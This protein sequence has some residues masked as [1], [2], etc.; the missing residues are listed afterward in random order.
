VTA[1][2]VLGLLAVV[3]L[4]WAG[5]LLRNHEVGSDAALRS[6]FA[7]D[8][9]KAQRD[10]DLEQLEDAEL[11]DPS[12]SWELA[13][14]NYRLVSGD[15]RGAARAG[16]ALVRE[17]PDNIGAW[18]LLLRATQESDPQRSREAAA[19]IRRLNPLGSRD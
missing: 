13:A 8:A 5:V 16:E 2:V 11:L 19:E 7:A 12:S 4:A 15:M 1:R 18:T 9:S 3:V 17:E 10:R 6:F 14:G